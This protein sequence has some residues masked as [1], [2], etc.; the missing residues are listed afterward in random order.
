VIVKSGF[1]TMDLVDPFCVK[2]SERND[3]SL[4]YDKELKGLDLVRRDWCVLSKDT[5]R[6][7]IDQVRSATSTRNRPR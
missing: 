1:V 6:Y 2:V 5:G 4:G 3:G 7:V